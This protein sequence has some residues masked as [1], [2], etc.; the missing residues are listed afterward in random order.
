MYIDKHIQQIRNTLLA[1]KNPY[2]LYNDSPATGSEEERV[3]AEDTFYNLGQ[4]MEEIQKM[5][6][7][8][9]LLDSNPLAH[10]RKYF[11]KFVW[12]SHSSPTERYKDIIR[13]ADYIWHVSC[14]GI[15]GGL[16]K[17]VTATERGNTSRRRICYCPNK[18]EDTPLMVWPIDPNWVKETEALIL[19]PTDR[20]TFV[21]NCHLSLPLHLNLVTD[22]HIIHLPERNSVF[23]VLSDHICSFLLPLP[24]RVYCEELLCFVL[25][26]SSA[27]AHTS[28]QSNALSWCRLAQD[29]CFRRQKNGT[30]PF[31]FFNLY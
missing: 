2:E 16:S 24:E 15:G 12:E 22:L 18:F 31:F 6:E 25:L 1:S 7:A 17:Y 5:L 8:D 9:Y 28:G 21:H 10:L 4:V 26:D 14:D 27:E 23:E 3:G 11:P 30:W 29:F 19:V 13:G 20:G